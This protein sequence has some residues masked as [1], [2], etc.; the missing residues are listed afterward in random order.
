MN[1]ACIEFTEYKLLLTI[2]QED[3]TII[4]REERRFRLP[5]Q[6]LRLLSSQE[7]DMILLFCKELLEIAR[8]HQVNGWNVQGI[9][10]H[11]TQRIVNINHLFHQITDELNISFQIISPEE[12]VIYTWFGQTAAL[13]LQATSIAT[14]NLHIDGFECIFGEKNQ[15]LYS[16]EIDCNLF[17]L[18][19]AC[20]GRDFDHYSQ[21]GIIEMKQ[22]LDTSSL[23]LKWPKRPRYLVFQ[24]ELIDYLSALD[25]S[26]FAPNAPTLLQF[27]LKTLRKWQDF[28]LNSD[29]E[30]RNAI[31]EK[32][33]YPN[34]FLPIL[35]VV[36]ALCSRSFHD[37]VIISNGDLSYGLLLAQLNE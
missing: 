27:D 9:A 19:Q 15:I 31:S 14:I 33:P 28:I 34:I 7:I 16:T 36:E 22:E 17:K 30:E 8:L 2:I 11:R 10:P 18:N 13:E 32:I 6:N 23:L 20:F 4:L 5:N 3:S 21:K 37:S 35:L 25:L 26:K 24:G 29:R 12:Q 1:H